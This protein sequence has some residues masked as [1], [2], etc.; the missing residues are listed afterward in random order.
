MSRLM[1]YFFMDDAND[2]PVTPGVESYPLN[3]FHPAATMHMYPPGP[4]TPASLN[5][6][7]SAAS[8]SPATSVGEEFA[9]E[10]LDDPWEPAHKESDDD[11]Q[12]PWEP[13]CKERDDDDQRL[14]EPACRK[15]DDNDQW[16]NKI[17]LKEVDQSFRLRDDVRKLQFS[18]HD[19]LLR[20]R[21]IQVNANSRESD[22]RSVIS[23]YREHQ[24]F[25]EHS[26]ANALTI[27]N[28]NHQKELAE[29]QMALGLHKA[30]QEART[31]M[32]LAEKDALFQSEAR[33]AKEK[34]LAEKETELARLS[35][36]YSSKIASLNSQMRQANI[37]K[38]PSSPTSWR[39]LVGKKPVATCTNIV[40]FSIIP[41]ANSDSDGDK[42]SAPPLTS[43]LA[44]IPIQN[45]TIGMLVEALA[46]VLIPSQTTSPRAARSK[47]NSHEPPTENFT[48]VQRR[49]NKANVRELFYT[50]FN[51]AKD[52]EYMLHVTALCEAISSFT[53][54]LG[55][56]PDPLELHWDMTTTHKSQWNQKKFETRKKVTSV[57]LSDR[58]ATGKDDQAVWAYLQSLVETLG[59]DGMS[60]DE[61]EH[62]D[63]EVQVFRLKKMSWRADINH[64]MHIIDQQQLVGA[65]ANFTPYGSK[66]AKRFR[67][68]IRESSHPAVEG[69]PRAL[70]NSSWLNDQPPSFTVSDKK[71]QRMEIIVSPQ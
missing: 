28:E 45:A 69:L 59:K 49:N 9:M 66:P 40:G 10:L 57:L 46:K 68:A 18:M 48:D 36:E 5:Y 67:N 41:D 53:C 34:L 38:S 63:G 4:V 42:G 70:Y 27:L 16:P 39:H 2:D 60:S 11:D 3:E 19:L 50:V 31:D 64:D 61:S 6:R 15:R 65:A 47:H 55:M 17:F 37:T 43:L 62:K 51:L 13:A 12:Q 32:L 33:V 22:L 54:G 23:Q 24:E 14:C 71:L 30:P 35:A 8:P 25:L 58:I 1:S 21:Q 20:K 29:S 26:K 44:D 7:S 52:D 56:G